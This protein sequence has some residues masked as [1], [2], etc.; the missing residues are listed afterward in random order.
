MPNPMLRRIPRLHPNLLVH[1]MQP[2]HKTQCPHDK[3]PLHIPQKHQILGKVLDHERHHPP[4]R[5]ARLFRHPPEQLD[6]PPPQ[7]PRDADDG[8]GTEERLLEEVPFLDSFDD[9]SDVHALP[10][11][12]REDV[13]DEPRREVSC[14]D[15]LAVADHLTLSGLVLCHEVEQN[16]DREPHFRQEYEGTLIEHAIANPHVSTMRSQQCPKHGNHIPRYLV[17]MIGGYDNPPRSW[18]SLHPRQFSL[19]S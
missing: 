17:R 14:P 7:H 19:S 3:R 10:R 12:Q 2:M 11:D 1:I 15:R 6:V 13:D 4:Q 16:V 8:L 18:R 5:R 9:G